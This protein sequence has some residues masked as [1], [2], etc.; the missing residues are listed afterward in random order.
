LLFNSY[1]FIF[2][3]LPIV[4]L[5]FFICQKIKNQSI[6]IL[7]LIS[8]SLFFYGWWNTKYLILI[9][10]SVLTNFALGLIIERTRSKVFLI[11]GL[12]FNIA[13]IGY[14]KYAN[15]F[16]DNINLFIGANIHLNKVILPLAISFFTFQQIAYLVDTYRGQAKQ[17]QFLHYCLFVTF[18]PQLIAGPIVQHKEMMPQF[19][20]GRF[21]SLRAKNLAIGVSIFA[22]G[23]FKKIVIADGIS[24]YATP[25]FD[26]AE[27]NVQLTFFEAWFGTL[28]Y[29]MQL[30]FDFSGY[31]DMAI[32]LAQIFGLKLPVNFFSPYKALNIADFW[33]RWH[34]TLSRLI[35]EYLWDPISLNLTRLGFKYRLSSVSFFLLATIVPTLFT[36]FWV[37]LWHGAGWN[38]IIF[39]LLHGSFIVIFNLWTKIKQNYPRV[40]IIKNRHVVNSIAWIIT[41]VSV[42]IGWVFFRAESFTGAKNIVLAMF[43]YNHITLSPYLLGKIGPLEEVLLQKGFKFD[44]MFSNGVLGN[45]PF[46]AIQLI[47]FLLVCCLVLPNCQQ[48]FSKYKP[49]ISTYNEAVFSYPKWFFWRP[50]I[51]WIILIVFFFMTALLSVNK[52]SEFLYFQF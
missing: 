25:M 32:G 24:V 12:L 40:K 26:A 29:S 6:S 19:K 3:F 28:A 1:I 35:R 42:L 49:Y 43:G 17:Y 2:C 13:L 20:L 4:I 37:G 50:T 38:F 31:S 7:W 47:L 8:S 21:Y 23:L 39:G 46:T 22:I 15:F 30:Y 45:E 14:F 10:I 51:K 11:L 5:G 9:I 34:I 44:G 33:R 41:F 27:I 48:I 16:V 36:F 52:E 18:F